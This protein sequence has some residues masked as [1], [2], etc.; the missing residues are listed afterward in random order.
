METVSESKPPRQTARGRR[1]VPTQKEI[2]FVKLFAEN[3][4]R[5][6]MSC[7]LCP[8][9]FDSIDEAR[10]HYATAHKNPKGYIKCCNAK[11]TYRSDISKHINH[12]INLSRSQ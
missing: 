5:F 6:N 8:K 12:H 9:I 7:D 1:K 11:L 4:H 10:R 2:D 3:K